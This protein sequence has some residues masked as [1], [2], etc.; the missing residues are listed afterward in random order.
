[1]FCFIWY[2]L[3]TF[4]I[5]QGRTIHLA[6]SAIALGPRIEFGPRAQQN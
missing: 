4:A 6:V 3:Q 2:I 1:M 5:K